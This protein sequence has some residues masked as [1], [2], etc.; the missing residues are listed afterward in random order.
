MLLHQLV[1]PIHRVSA[2]SVIQSDHPT[3]RNSSMKCL[4]DLSVEQLGICR[5]FVER[6]SIVVCADC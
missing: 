4:L 3:H 1:G 5:K 2:K 6:R